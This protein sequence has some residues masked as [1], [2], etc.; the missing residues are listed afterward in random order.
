MF[1]GLDIPAITKTVVEDIR[2]EADMDTTA[3]TPSGRAEESVQ[4]EGFDTVV[5]SDISN[6]DWKKIEAL[7]WLVFDVSQRPEAV[8][9]CNALMRSFLSKLK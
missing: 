8:R 3:I 2:L 9:Q 5:E 6:D 7:D 1:S 4:D